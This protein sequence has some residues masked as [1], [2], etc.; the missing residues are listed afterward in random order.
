MTKKYYVTSTKF[1]T[2]DKWTKILYVYAYYIFLFEYKLSGTD[3]ECYLLP[4]TEE[5]NGIKGVIE[6]NSNEKNFVLE[7]GVLEKLINSSTPYD[8]IIVEEIHD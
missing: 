7:D 6:I 5:F 4:S 3:E 2:F 8:H 1:I